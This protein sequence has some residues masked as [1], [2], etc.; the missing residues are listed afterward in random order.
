MLI[1]D[2]PSDTSPVQLIKLYLSRLQI[3]DDCNKFIFRLSVKSNLS[4]VLSRH[5]S[6][7]TFREHLKS[8]LFGIVDDLSN[9]G[10]H[11]LRSGGCTRAANAGIEERLIVRHGRWR[12]VSSKNMYMD[13][14]LSKKVEI[15]NVIQ[16]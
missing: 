3:P 9:F 14:A 5:I 1:S 7:C 6:Y 8:D 10:S 16:S 13:D 12:S 11:S 4:I 15:S 2:S